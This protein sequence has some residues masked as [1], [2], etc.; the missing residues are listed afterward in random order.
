MI[1]R[2]AIVATGSIAFDHIMTF[3]DHF[4]NHILPEKVH[5]ISVSFLLDS[6][7]RRRGGCAANISYNLALLGHRPLLFGTAGRDFGEYRASLDKAGV[8]TT[9][10]AV[11]EEE[12]TASAFITTDLADNQIIG[13]Y[14]GAMGHAHNLSLE[15]VRSPIDVVVISPN[16]PPAMLK[17]ADECRRLGHAFI[18]DPGQSI[19]AFSGDDLTG[20]ARGANLVI[21]NDY[22]LELVRSKTGMS[23][24]DLL[25]LTPLVVQT[26]GE[27][28]SH[29]IARE[30]EFAVPA[31]KP[32]RIADPTGAGDAFRAGLLLALQA[33]VEIETAAKVGTLAATYC[34]EASGPQG[35]SARSRRMR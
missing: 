34:V 25:E 32:R 5:M 17:Y 16:D 8:D 26:L 21:G 11:I 29:L 2:M 24:G 3:R 22:E 23:P 9:Y 28:G 12:L 13:F 6:L 33:G 31:I 14:P 19:P 4:K 10:A 35:H 27:K 1:G 20:A 7:D 18:F 15:D 30:R